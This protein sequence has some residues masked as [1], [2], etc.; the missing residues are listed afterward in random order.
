MNALATIL[1]NAGLSIGADLLVRLT[2]AILFVSITHAL[3]VGAAG[4]FNLG[5]TYFLLTSRFGYWGLDHLLIREVSPQP[6]LVGQ[7]FY[8]FAFLRILLAIVM[9][10]CFSAVVWQL[11]YAYETRVT[12]LIML[13]AVLPEN[14]NNI[15]QS[16]FIAHERMEYIGIVAF[17]VAIVRV[18][19]SLLL[20]WSGAGVQVLA[21]VYTSTSFLALFLFL[22]IVLAKYVPQRWTIDLEF[23]RRNLRIA[24]PFAVIGAVFVADNRVDVLSLSFLMDEKAVGIYSA[25]ATIVTAFALLPQ[26][27]RTAIF[28]VLAR[29]YRHKPESVTGLYLQ[30]FKYLL[31]IALP[32]TAGVS[33]LGGPIIELLYPPE[34]LPAVA[35][36][37]ILIWSLLFYS[38]NILNSR[39]LIVNNDQR[40]IA[41][42]LI[43]G[44][45]INVLLN[46]LLVPRVGLVGASIAK[47]TASAAIFLQSETAAH[48]VL[49]GPSVWPVA[50]RPG[51][52]Y[53]LMAGVVWLARDLNVWV[54]AGL[55]AAVYVTALFVF[56]TFTSQERSM[57]RRA[58]MG[59]T[60]IGAKDGAKAGP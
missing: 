48:R 30:L 43:V 40:L 46:V 51:A 39:I 23:C 15:C 10:G 58:L 52:A 44:L 9:I 26:G 19:I 41:L 14:I 42:Y 59:I 1:R 54:L 36:L 18:G 8:N 29:R 35:V 28:P 24:A 7:Y 32:I 31:V 25:A 12:I 13:I 20:L 49:G 16:V 17:F 2:N 4:A 53:A 21:I 57:W 45:G 55:G 50:V 11:S 27:L 34:F 5:I 6:R 3:G 56:G 22:A 60:Q 38:L 37:R 33:L 47:V